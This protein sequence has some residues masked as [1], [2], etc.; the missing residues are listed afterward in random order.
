[1]SKTDK[2]QQPILV[3]DSGMG[4]ISVLKEL[5]VL[6]PEEDFLY[7]GDSKNAPYGMKSAEEVKELTCTHVESFYKQG[8]KALCVACNT[9]TSAAVK[10]LRKQYPDMPLVGIEPALKP[11]VL[12]KE[13]PS[14]LVMATPM[15]IREE[16]FQNL[17][18]Q[19]EDAADIIPLPCPGLME[20]I[21][22]N[23]FE[24]PQFEQFLEQ[25]LWD[26]RD[27]RCDAAVLGCTHYSFVKR[28][29][30]KA[31]GEKTKLFDG[32]FGTAR[33]LKRRIEQAGLCRQQHTG[34]VTFI[35]S[36]SSSQKEAFYKSLLWS[37]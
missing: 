17:L 36:D 33:E 27:S 31:L 15:T 2:K 14:V 5:V 10:T 20:F 7:F 6:L 29:I 11:A 4:G 18:L 3:F 1:M 22:G 23:Q 26:Y 34:K 13:R 32:A 25:L 12:S 9:A 30:Q 35:N 21:E 28:Q 24:T 8:I 37:E 16:K 19:Y